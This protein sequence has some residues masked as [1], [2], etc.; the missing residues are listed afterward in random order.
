MR[1][2]SK[3]IHTLL[4]EGA[5]STLAGYSMVQPAP[6]KGPTDGPS[7]HVQSMGKHDPAK[8]QASMTQHL[9]QYKAKLNATPAQEAAW[10]T[11]TDGIKPTP[12]TS[13]AASH[14]ELSQRP[15]SERLERVRALHTE[16]MAAMTTRMDLRAD[17]IKTFYAVLNEDQKKIFDD[18]FSQ[19]AGV[20]SGHRAGS[21]G[22]QH[23][24]HQHPG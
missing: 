8:M 11:F 5:I 24:H 12:H 13:M 15:T 18:Q 1:T 22:G 16:R 4:L 7:A 2:Y 23:G 19:L 10:T 6:G 3:P 21:R 9:E 17:V 14:A 20:N